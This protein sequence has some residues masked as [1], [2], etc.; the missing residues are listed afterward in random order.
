MATKASI[1][2][3]KVPKSVLSRRPGL[4]II[5]SGALASLKLL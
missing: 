5:Q 2:V 1:V 3:T 4:D